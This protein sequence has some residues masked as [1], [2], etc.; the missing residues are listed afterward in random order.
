ML[1]CYFEL[2]IGMRDFHLGT[3][4]H[5]FVTYFSFIEWQYEDDYELWDETDGGRNGS[6]VF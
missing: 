3:A 2:D 4:V 6:A 5:F 1:N